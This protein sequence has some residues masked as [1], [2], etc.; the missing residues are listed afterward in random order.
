[1]VDQTPSPPIFAA[2]FAL[3]DALPAVLAAW[4]KLSREEPWHIEP[5][6]FGVDALSEVIRAVLDAA[7]DSS[8]ETAT[9]ERLVHSAV[10]HGEQR[11]A[12]G[13]GD[14]AV[15]RE[16]HALRQTL[17]R[18]LERAVD[19]DSGRRTSD[20]GD[21]DALVAVF[22]IDI[23][24]SAATTAALRGYHREAAGPAAAWDATVIRFV[25]D[26]SVL[27]AAGL[28]PGPK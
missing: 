6:R 26:A 20:R 27:L 10:S 9:F 1:M 17:W 18:L 2:G 12:Q 13:A 15:L 22:R 28:H 21:S 24:I 14:D 11:R 23:A 25:R 19:R 3:R 5:D 7:T 8:A 16:Y 4:E